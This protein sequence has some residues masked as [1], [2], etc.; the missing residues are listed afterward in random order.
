MKKIFLFLLFLVLWWFSYSV[1]AAQNITLSHSTYLS[2]NGVDNA[3]WLQYYGN[4]LYIWLN[5]TYLH[6]SEIIRSGN[7]DG[8]WKI[9]IFDVGNKRIY[10][11]IVLDSE[12]ID[13]EVKNDLIY[14]ITRN[15]TQ[16]LTLNGNVLTTKPQAVKMSVDKRGNY[17]LLNSNNELFLYDSNNVLRFQQKLSRTSVEDILLDDISGRVFVVWYDEKIVN[18]TSLQVAFLQAFDYNGSS[19]YELFGFEAQTL[20]QNMA[21]TRLYK[22][23]LWAD[24]KVYILWETNGANTIFRYNWKTISGNQSIT[25]IDLFTQLS[26]INNAD[27]A[28]FAR[29]N[30]EDGNI[31]RSSFSL[32][33][34]QNGDA[35]SYKVKDGN[36]IADKSGNIVIAWVNSASFPNRENILVNGQKL[37]TY[38]GWDGTLQSLNNNFSARYFWTSFGKSGGANTQMKDVVFAWDTI[39]ALGTVLNG[40]V[41][42]TDNTIRKNSNNNNAFLVM[43]NFDKYSTLPSYGQESV[44]S[45]TGNGGIIWGNTNTPNNSSSNLNLSA[46]AQYDEYIKT[47]LA[48]PNIKNAEKLQKYI[49]PNY[50]TPKNGK[51]AKIYIILSGKFNEKKNALLKSKRTITQ[52]DL[53]VFRNYTVSLYNL[54][55]AIDTKK[56]TSELKKLYRYFAQDYKNVMNIK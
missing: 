16:I 6:S 52:A 29:I 54:M 38:N 28:Y 10:R 37:D 23:A 50:Y 33:R 13:F 7:V 53:D 35:N 22:L 46:A 18:N 3:V 9:F 45:N 14:A 48:N 19:K 44:G 5:T 21:A 40:E 8:R 2:E 41:F 24:E 32:S 30:P 1:Q 12:L 51:A 31:E 36:V 11:Q 49:H 34:L 42:T 47:A 39:I 25:S 4:V 20:T 56:P 26:Q 43:F 55:Y 27:I 17:L 15:S